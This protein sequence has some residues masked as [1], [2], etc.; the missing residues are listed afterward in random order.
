MNFYASCFQIKI[1]QN[2]FIVMNLSS[3]LIDTACKSIFELLDSEKKW[4]LK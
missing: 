3:S 1:L 4:A 2:G